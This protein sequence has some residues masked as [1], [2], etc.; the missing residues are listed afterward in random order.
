[1]ERRRHRVSKSAPSQQQIA[2]KLSAAALQEQAL[3]PLL[4]LHR[5]SL[6]G[7]Q[8]NDTATATHGACAGEQRSPP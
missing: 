2:P 1:V 7:E 6:Q 5:E 4:R 8:H 3:A